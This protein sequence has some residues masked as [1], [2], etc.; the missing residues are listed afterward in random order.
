M[1]L[2]VGYETLASI[3]RKLEDTTIAQKIQLDSSIAHCFLQM[4]DHLL[5]EAVIDSAHKN[6]KLA[7]ALFPEDEA[8]ADQYHLIVKNY[9]QFYHHYS[10]Y[11]DALK[12]LCSGSKSI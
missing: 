3:I 6:I 5:E 10:K 9:K 2:S 4:T 11:S 7:T 12:N 1:E 8:V